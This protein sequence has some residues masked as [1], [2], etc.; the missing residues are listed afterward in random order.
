MIQHTRTN[1]LLLKEKSRSVE[2]SIGL[3]KARRQALMREFLN[4]VVPF[5]R[6]KDEIRNIYG[7]A[8]N[9]LALSMAYEGRDNIVSIAFAAKRVMQLSAPIANTT[10]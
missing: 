5:I 1:L 9:E 8:I 6:S 3:L 4:T 2:D 7:K 10:S